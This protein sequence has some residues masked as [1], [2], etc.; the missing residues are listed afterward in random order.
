MG[1]HV[2]I[3]GFRQIKTGNLALLEPVVQVSIGL[4]FR[5][6]FVVF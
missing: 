4:R 6:L 2:G 3:S 1:V 5:C